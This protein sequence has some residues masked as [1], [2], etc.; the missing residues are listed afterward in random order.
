MRQSTIQSP[1][2]ESTQT[3]KPG[4]GWRSPAWWIMQL[5]GLIALSW[6]LIRVIP[7]PSRAT[8]PCQRAAFPVASSFVI[9]I[10]SAGGWAAATKKMRGGAS[11]SRW[12]T[13]LL[14][15][16][17]VAVCAAGYFLDNPGDDSFAQTTQ[18]AVFKPSE[19]ANAPMGAA[20]G[21][22]PGR[23]AWIFDPKATSWDGTTNAPGWWDDANTHPQQVS[24]MLSAV[25]RS[26]G[27]A[28]TD[29]EAWNK[30]FIDFNQRKGKTAGYAPGEKIAI[31]LNLNQCRSHGDNAN[32]SYIAPQLVEALLQQLVTE[33][34]VAP[35]DIYCYDAIR[36][37][38]STIFDRCT[39]K[40]PGVHMVDSTGT[41][42]REKAVA[43]TNIKLVLTGD[44]LTS[45]FPTCLTQATYLI[46]VAGLK[47][48]TLAGMTVTAKNHLGSMLTATGGSAAQAIHPFLGVRG[49][50]GG[51]PQQMGDYNGLVDLNGHAQTGGKTV[52]YLVDAL[53][54][55]KTNETRLDASTKW[56][57]APFNG[58]WT[59]SLM[60]SQDGVAIDSVS[61]DFL[62][63]EPSIVTVT[64]AV[65]NYMH[66][67]AQLGNPGWKNAYD[68]E[69]D[70]K[71]ITTSL[72]VHEH[73]N[74]A[75]EKKY[76]RN[77][78]SSGKG[79]ELMTLQPKTVG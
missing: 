72:G 74:N 70:G 58:G 16:I 23:V 32:A 26:V 15:A 48:H 75:A 67:M 54:A 8:Y 78:S 64:G 3:T 13:A 56:Q 40:F 45:Y 59:S 2:N 73:W 47:G 61:L 46:N 68:P 22:K 69:K 17:L 34:G 6:F 25:I 44:K 18:Q 77:E 37:V 36:Q 4:F 71:N 30:I 33:V 10:I 35:S 14:G 42:G 31:K 65:D 53:Y 60:A 11:R 20:F 49:G 28:S 66:E 63:N 76:S 27:D 24:A 79:I 38:P 62:R 21:V 52:L 51:A 50:R 5:S 19:G 29:K 57:S 43:D 55:T 7:K 39:K 1:Q 41:D 9:W 12:S